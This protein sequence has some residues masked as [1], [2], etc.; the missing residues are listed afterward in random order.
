MREVLFWMIAAAVACNPAYAEN[1]STGGKGDHAGRTEREMKEIVDRV[2]ARF[3]QIRGFSARFEQTFHNVSMGTREKAHGTVV[4]QKPLKMRWE[5]KA[6]NEQTMVS[7][8]KTLYF[9]LPAEKQVMAEPLDNVV[10]SRSPALFLVGGKKL[11]EIFVIK[12]VAENGDDS[13]MD[14]GISL[15]L[16]PKEKSISVTRI[17]ISV[18][19]RDYTIRALSIYDW[20]GNRSDI[21]FSGMKINEEADNG[22]FQFTRPAGVELIE[23]PRL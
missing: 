5:Y 10:N 6:P 4:M 15:A 8:G 21:E 11:N 1:L 23:P 14:K 20:V 9:Y 19:A 2:E 16:E 3:E 12:P 22:V 13:R 17:V 7:N 18:D